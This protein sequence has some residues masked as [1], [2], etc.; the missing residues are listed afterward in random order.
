MLLSIVIPAHNE[1]G[2]IR[3]C[4][5]SLIAQDSPAAPE[6][7]VEVIVVANAC[8]DRTAALA[9]ELEPLA[10]ARGYGW[11][12]IEDCVGGKARALNR[13]DAMARGGIRVYLDADVVCS[14]TL[15]GEL[16]TA[17]EGDAPL[18]ASGAITIPPGASWVSR[19]YGEFWSRL[20]F[21]AA[22]VSG[23]G[24]Y[25]VNAAGRRRWGAFPKLHSDDKFV[26]LLFS[27][28]ERRRVAARYSWPV[29][30]GLLTLLRVRRRW[31]EG[32]AE[33]RHA[34][35]DLRADSGP[36]TAWQYARLALSRPVSACVF[37]IIY[38][39][40]ALLAARH[41]TSTP[42]QWRRARQ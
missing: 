39:G 42:I 27:R 12:V 31:C 2:V 8:S 7:G 13:G 1:E 30:E 32:N 11:T 22:D 40:G 5:E 38:A 23:C 3:P 9:R 14:P 26:R 29:P 10:R 25:A 37:S 35:P 18:Y 24:L 34:Y 17:L 41:E 16:A 33:L 4:L 28:A 6:F 15:L 21:V 36:G 19:R 20:P